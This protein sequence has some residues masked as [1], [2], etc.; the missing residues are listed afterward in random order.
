MF[1]TIGVPVIYTLDVIGDMPTNRNQELTFTTFGTHTTE[2]DD[3][4]AYIT[5]Q[6]R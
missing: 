3:F 1:G 4:L 2:G 5:V 6:N